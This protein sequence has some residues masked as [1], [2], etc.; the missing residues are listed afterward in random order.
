[1]SLPLVVGKTRPM[2]TIIPVAFV[3]PYALQFWLIP[4]VPAQMGK[5]ADVQGR[6]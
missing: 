5:P 6:V 4:T 1:V 3:V 2:F